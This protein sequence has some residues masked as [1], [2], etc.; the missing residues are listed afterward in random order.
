MNHPQF[1]IVADQS[2]PDILVLRDV[3]PWDEHPTVTNAIERVIADLRDRYHLPPG[4]RL[5]YYDSHGELTEALLD[6]D[7]RFAG[8]SCPS[9]NFQS[10][11]EAGDAA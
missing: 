3:G 4:R 10:P 11:K 9:W 8:Y 1:E 5:F 6:S 7:G 2:T